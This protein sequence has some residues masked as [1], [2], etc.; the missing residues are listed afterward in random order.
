MLTERP[1]LKNFG[2]RKSELIFYGENLPC[3]LYGR[4]DAAK[5]TRLIK[6]SIGLTCCNGP[7]KEASRGYGV[8]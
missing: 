6:T 8:K 2:W 4:D 5:L 3:G 7:F 1:A